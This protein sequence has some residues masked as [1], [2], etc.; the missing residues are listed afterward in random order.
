M[1]AIRGVRGRPF[2]YASAAVQEAPA[3]RMRPQLI[4]GALAVLATVG[5]GSLECSR[6]ALTPYEQRGHRLYG[7]MCSVCHGASGEGYKADNAPRLRHPDFLASASDAFLNT[8]IAT[9]RRDTVM[10]AWATSRGGPLEPDDVQ[11]V[12]AF[13]RTWDY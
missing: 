6:G 2:G 3:K 9:G 7:R 5:G 1:Q 13:L 10:S 12:V 11:A 8:A 4:V